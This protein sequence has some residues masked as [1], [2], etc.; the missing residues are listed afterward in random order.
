M[1]SASLHILVAYVGF[2]IVAAEKS[3]F[4]GTW[5]GKMN[6]LPGVDV[7]IEGSGGKLSG[8]VVFYFQMRGDESEKWRVQDKSTVRIINPR[9]I[10]NILTF[11]VIHY[12][13]HGSSE[14]GPNAKFRMEIT[15]DDEAMLYR[16]DPDPGPPLKLA[17]RRK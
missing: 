7:T 4:S 12:K 11:E 1:R 15:G 10:G 9:V 3:P 13:T 2:T 14:R 8:I 17:R 5:E 16:V 6:D